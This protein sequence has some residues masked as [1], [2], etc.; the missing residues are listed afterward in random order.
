MPKIS[1][2]TANLDNAEGLRN[3]I[4]SVVSQ[5]YTD[6]EYIII[7]GGSTDG[8]QDVIKENAV[9]ISLWLSE[10]D[11]GVYDALNKGIKIA[12]G[13]WIIFMN[14]GDTFYDKNVLE[15]VFS[16]YFDNLTQI[17][18][19]NTI[20]KENGK[21]IKPSSRINKNFFFYETICHQSIFFKRTIFEKL[22]YHNLNYKIIADREFL[23]RSAI[24]NLK[25]VYIDVDVCIWEAEGL[26]SKNA[27]MLND[28]FEIMKN[29]YF[30]ILE[31]RVLRSRERISSFKD[32]IL[33][34]LGNKISV[35]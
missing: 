9:K 26:S 21:K 13:E 14:S 8:S 2:I 19:G 22:G 32:K 10:P 6:Y 4:K 18:Y 34:K 11:F 17:I 30:N 28:E 7:D 33:F 27:N 31:Q 24:R 25:F 35:L 15:K 29:M 3:T 20:V 16:H 5:T 1:I 12:C 23:L